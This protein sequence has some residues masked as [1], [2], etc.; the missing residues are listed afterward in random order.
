MAV[1][2]INVF[3]TKLVCDLIKY[4]AVAVAVGEIITDITGVEVTEI[5]NGVIKRRY[6]L[7]IPLI[8]TDLSLYLQ[9]LMRL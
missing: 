6:L 5:D 4:R 3:V 1:Q 9:P 8:W 7:N 2:I